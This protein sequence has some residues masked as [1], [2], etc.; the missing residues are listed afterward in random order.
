MHTAWNKILWSSLNGKSLFAFLGTI[1]GTYISMADPRCGCMS[2]RNAIQRTAPPR[3]CTNTL[4]SVIFGT[5]RAAANEMKLWIFKLSPP[6]P[7]LLNNEQSSRGWGTEFPFCK[8][9]K[10]R[11][12]VRGGNEK[13]TLLILSSSLSLRVSFVVRTRFMT[14]VVFAFWY[15]YGDPCDPGVFK[16][17]RWVKAENGAHNREERRRFIPVL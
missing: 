8:R 7:H 2:L 10:R 9:G 11:W 1:C 4:H 3:F 14:K 6:P 5:P 12:R 17:N 16:I 13:Q 15:A